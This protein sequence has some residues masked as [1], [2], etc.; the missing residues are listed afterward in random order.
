MP[1]TDRT[2]GRRPS[3]RVAGVVLA[4]GASTRFQAP[5]GEPKQL[6][7]IRGETL[8]R[9][10]CLEALASDLDETILVTGHARERVEAEVADLD[11]S[12]VHNAAYADGQSGSVCCGLGRV[13]TGAPGAMFLPV[14]Q[15]DLDAAVID[16]LLAAFGGPESIVVPAHHGRR[17]APVTFGRSW[18]ERLHELRGDQGARRLLPDLADHVLE[19]E[20][21]SGR[22]LRDVDTLAEARS[23]ADATVLQP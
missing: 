8:V 15:P 22:P 10:I 5:S 21:G 13:S 3:K 19:V 11:L 17:G 4:A 20:L 12:L 23:W 7:R 6:H 18:F 14:D 16:R 9:R 2:P 1:L